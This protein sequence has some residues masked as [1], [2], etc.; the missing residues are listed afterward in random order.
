MYYFFVF[1]P[2][3]V[4]VLQRLHSRSPEASWN[5]GG[6]FLGSGRAQVLADMQLRSEQ[7]CAQQQQGHQRSRAGETL[8][9]IQ[10]S[11]CLGIVS[12]DGGQA[13]RRV[14]LNTSL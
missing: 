5:I 12:T 2:G 6:C 9:D 7:L 3:H 4:P 14:V 10:P 13:R 11:L 8:V 1:C